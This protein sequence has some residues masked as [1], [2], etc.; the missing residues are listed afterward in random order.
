MTARLRH[1]SAAAEDGRR[2]A[3]AGGG[4]GDGAVPTLR[5]TDARTVPNM[6]KP[7]DASAS[8]D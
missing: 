5:S 3:A 6:K 8:S 2:V 4:V 1:A 7:E